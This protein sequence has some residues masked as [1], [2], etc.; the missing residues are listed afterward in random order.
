MARAYDLIDADGHVLYPADMRL[1]YI[2]P[3]FRD[4]GGLINWARPSGLPKI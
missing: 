4:C 2:D 3:K 1:K